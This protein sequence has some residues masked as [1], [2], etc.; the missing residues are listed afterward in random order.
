M[1]RMILIRFAVIAAVACCWIAP[2]PVLADETAREFKAG[3]RVEAYSRGKW[4]PATVVELNQT[5]GW[6]KVRLDDKAVADLP[7]NMR[8][9]FQTIDLPANLM[10]PSASHAAATSKSPQPQS[11]REKPQSR[12]WTDRGGKFT[13]EATF[14]ELHDGTVGLLRA[15]GKRIDVPLDKLSDADAKYV[16]SLEESESPFSESAAARSKRSPP[17]DAAG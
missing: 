15:D 8:A 2:L 16:H 5:H 6:T 12:T 13:V 7:E 9:A 1:V 14:V 3:D 17:S 4:E 11:T 10:R